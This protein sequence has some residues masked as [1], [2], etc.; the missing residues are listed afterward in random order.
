M[1]A[2]RPTR[3]L[4][5]ERRVIDVSDENVAGC[6]LFLE[7]A[8]QTER[9]V[10]FGQ[11]SLVHAAVRRMTD[12]ATLSHRFVLVHKGTAL[13]RVTLEAGFV[14]AEERKSTAFKPL[15]DI[16]RGALGRNPFVRL[17]AI[18]AAHLSFEHRM[19]MR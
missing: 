1:A 11:Q 13:L 7:M 10:A 17:M 5:Q 8:F 9:G 4:L 3:S 19:M 12:A 16:C 18:A 14:S 15:L 2:S 6:S